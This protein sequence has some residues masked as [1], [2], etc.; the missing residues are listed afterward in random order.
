MVSLSHGSCDLFPLVLGRVH[1]RGIVGAGV[2]EDD[3]A[4]W[5]GPDG[6]QHSIDVKPF[7]LG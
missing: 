3:G 2:Q 6:R 5:G 7:Q 4:S 1:A